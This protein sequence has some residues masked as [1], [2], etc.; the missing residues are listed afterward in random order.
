MVCAFHTFR[1]QCLLHFLSVPQVLIPCNPL[2]SIFL[3][4]LV[5]KYKLWFSLY[6]LPFLRVALSLW[7]WQNLVKSTFNMLSQR[8]GAVYYHFAWL[9]LKA[10][11]SLQQWNTSV[12]CHI[13]P[14]ERTRK[15]LR[16]RVR[17]SRAN[18]CW[19]VQKKAKHQLIN[20]R[21]SAANCMPWPCGSCAHCSEIAW[22]YAQYYLL[23]K[24]SRWRAM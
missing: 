11:V 2:S 13:S 17:T 8:E 20:Q 1:F 6:N 15:L 22:L 10:V 12:L 21:A 3:S 14:W 18:W 4:Y 24:L 5:T 16:I 9:L 19:H 7:T 23:Q